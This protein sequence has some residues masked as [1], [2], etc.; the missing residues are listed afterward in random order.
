VEHFRPAPPTPPVLR[1]QITAPRNGQLALGTNPNVGGIALSPDATT[2]AMVATVDGKAGL[3]LSPLDGPRPVEGINNPS[4]P[5]WSP[6]QQVRR[7]LCRRIGP[8]S[9]SCNRSGG[10]NLYDPWIRRG[11][12]VAG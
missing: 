2:I 12:G 11:R 1:Y 8:A 4:Y 5:F 6:G 7:L 9:R 10:R 3:W